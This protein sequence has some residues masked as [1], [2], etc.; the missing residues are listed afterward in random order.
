MDFVV[1]LLS[2]A[3][4]GCGV[5]GSSVTITGF[6]IAFIDVALLFTVAFPGLTLD[7]PPELVLPPL[8]AFEL[9]AIDGVAKGLLGLITTSSSLPG[10]VI[11]L[12][13]ATLIGVV[14]VVWVVGV[15]GVLGFTGVTGVIGL[16]GFIGLGFIGVTGV[17][18][19]GITTTLGS[20]L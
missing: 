7:V 12:G 2:C 8:L 9:V 14:G 11:R 4:C 3:F 5:F 15:V 20:F 13:V 18:G 17:K 16:I 19:P 10:I 6:S 1:S